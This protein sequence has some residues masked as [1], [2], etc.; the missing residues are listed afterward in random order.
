MKEH[1][2]EFA[3]HRSPVVGTHGTVASSQP[4]A[5]AAGLAVLQKGGNAVDAAVATAAA[6]N[7]TEPGSTGL[8]G[9]AFCL[10]Y[11]AESRQVYSLN[12]SG[13]APLA[14]SLE[15]LKKEGLTL[16]RR[17]TLTTS[18][19]LAPVQA[20]VMR[21]TDMDVWTWLRCWH[22]RLGWL[23]VGSLLHQLQLTDGRLQRAWY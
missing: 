16:Y 10:I 18:L 11:N 3:T 5:T 15:R 23:R 17:D 1:Q 21:S 13:R 6:L 22:R 20:G 7:V 4:L 9:D 19:F 2:L 12:A 14:L 8:G